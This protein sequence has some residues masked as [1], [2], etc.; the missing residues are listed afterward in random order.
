MAFPPR[1][2]AVDN[3]MDID[4]DFMRVALVEA[5]SALMAGEVPVGALLVMEGEIVSRAHNRPIALA[6]PSAHAEILAIREAAARRGNYRLTGATLYVTLEPCLMCTGA[7][8]QA[9]IDR[10]VFGALDPKG[11]AVL[12]LYQVG[13]ERKLNHSFQVRGGVLEEESSGLLKAFFRERRDRS[14]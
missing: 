4:V 3:K 2:F 10:L 11:G 14:Y 7:I 8:I 6:D 13:S 5:K 12:S 9:R 1:Q